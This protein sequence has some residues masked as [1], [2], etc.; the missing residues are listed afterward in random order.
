[1]EAKDILVSQIQ[2]PTANDKRA[3]LV[4]ID[5]YAN[6]RRLDAAHADVKSI[7]ERLAQHAD[8]SP[9]YACE[10]PARDGRFTK[11]EL[12]QACKR[13]F[14]PSFR[15]DALFY[16]SGHGVIESTGGIFATSDGQEDDWG[17]SMH[18]VVELA[19]NSNAR[20]VTIL[21]DCC[22][23]GA[24]ADGPGVAGGVR[25][26]VASIREDMTL[27]AASRATQTAVESSTHGI[28]TQAVLDALDGAAAD[29]MGWVT[30]SAIYDL[31]E[32]RFGAWDQR[33]V[34]KSHVTRSMVIRK[35]APLIERHALARLVNLFS[36]ADYKYPLEPAHDPED[37]CGHM[38]APVD[39]AKLEIGR[40][41]KRYRDAGLLR[42]SIA[43]EQLFWTARRSHTVELTMR[44]REYWG[45]VKRG[46]L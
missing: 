14:H 40:L 17:V 28:F 27:L 9:N 12:M 29:A 41:F 44:G 4:G 34:Y 26:T 35:C 13:L 39:E 1:M 43:S 2:E 18:D 8:G 45:L 19:R 42:P 15:G 5:E 30:P 20:T 10:L 23:A 25:N 6:A 16:F 11:R 21:A 7:H 38:A 22:H 3:L 33:P 32:R 24:F 31:V 36:T 46:R 37:E